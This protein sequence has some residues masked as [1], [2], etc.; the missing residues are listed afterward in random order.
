MLWAASRKNGK[1]RG[2]TEHM[3]V[4][5]QKTETRVTK[6]IRYQQDFPDRRLSLLEVSVIVTALLCLLIFGVL[7]LNKQLMK[8][9]AHQMAGQPI[10]C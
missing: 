9:Q 2:H 4:N 8:N 7:F 6:A 3:M 5:F 1:L 10:C